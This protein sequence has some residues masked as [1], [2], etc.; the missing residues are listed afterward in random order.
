MLL[1]EKREGEL[2]SL[3]GSRIKADE[4]R[5]RGYE[6]VSPHA[7]SRELWSSGDPLRTP[8]IPHLLQFQNIHGKFFFFLSLT[9]FLPSRLD[10]FLLKRSQRHFSIFLID[11]YVLRFMI[12]WRVWRLFLVKFP[13]INSFIYIW[14]ITSAL[15]RK[16]HRRKPFKLVW[17]VILWH[18]LMLNASLLIVKLMRF[19]WHNFEKEGLYFFFIRC[20][21]YF[22][23]T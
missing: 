1:K 19:N 8:D 4:E 3:R 5:R 9:S 10:T 14:K 21:F 15:G 18:N 12:S 6:C 22:T 2:C 20:A 11:F 13:S 23:L 17:R 16:E 7:R